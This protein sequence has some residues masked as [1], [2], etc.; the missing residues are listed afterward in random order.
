MLL[1]T[2]FG[3]WLGV[4][5]KKAKDQ[6]RAVEA[7][8]SAGADVQFDVDVD[9]RIGR[10]HRFR[11]LPSTVPTRWA[12]RYRNWVR[13]LFGQHSIDK[14]V[15]VSFFREEAIAANH[16]FIRKRED[17]FVPIDPVR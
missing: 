1:V 10:W 5:V 15:S 4:V 3:A 13:P 12:K 16:D 14:V 6:E 11:A 9:T 17:S 8:L 7:L 2:I